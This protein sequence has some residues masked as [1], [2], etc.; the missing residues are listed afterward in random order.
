MGDIVNI[1]LV[2]FCAV[3]VRNATHQKIERGGAL[4]FDDRHFNNKYN[5]QPKVGIHGG[6]DIKEG[7]R[8]C[9]NCG[10]GV[11]PSIGVANQATK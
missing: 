8:P 9:R 2:L 5:N 10:S 11:I 3:G 4:A 1:Q 6:G 7:A